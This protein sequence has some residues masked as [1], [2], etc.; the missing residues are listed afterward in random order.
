MMATKAAHRVEVSLPCTNVHAVSNIKWMNNKQED[1]AL[2]GVLDAVA[3]D[4]SHGEQER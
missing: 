4:E 3:K 2:I 1:D